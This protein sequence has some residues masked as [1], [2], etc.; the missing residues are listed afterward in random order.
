[1]TAPFC[2]DVALGNLLEL[3][4]PLEVSPMLGKY[5][6]TPF[7]NVSANKSAAPAPLSIAAVIGTET[8]TA[9]LASGT[10]A[11]PLTFTV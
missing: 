9:M 3:I 1:M 10:N 6:C 2:D 5:L 11:V 4:V 8:S 7:A